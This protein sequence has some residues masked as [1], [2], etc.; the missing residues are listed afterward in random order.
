M[1]TIENALET[2]Y[3]EYT[4]AHSFIVGFPIL[5][6]VYY[7]FCDVNTLFQFAGKSKTSDEIPVFRLRVKPL[8]KK[9]ENIF[10]S[11]NP[12]TLCTVSELDEHAQL[13]HDGNRGKAFESLVIGAINARENPANSPFW[14][15]GDCEKDCEQIQIKYQ[16]ATIIHENHIAELTRIYK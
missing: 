13:F 10:L 15:C 5:D 16:F 9:T 3:K 11:L 12:Q 4:A 1:I 2:A 14:I 6:T 8:S 7:A